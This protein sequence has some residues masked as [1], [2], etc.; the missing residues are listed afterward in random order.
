MV[1]RKEQ[2]WNQRAWKAEFYTPESGRQ[3]PTA[4]SSL[5]QRPHEES[6]VRVPH[7]RCDLPDL[8]R[9]EDECGKTTIG[10]LSYTMAM[11]AECRSFLPT[12]IE[13]LLR[14][15]S[16]HIEWYKS[17]GCKQDKLLLQVVH[18]VSYRRGRTCEIMLKQQG[19]YLKQT[20]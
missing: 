6:G 17:C 19:Q 1:W 10:W 16:P 2:Y 11:I 15:V 14:E 8:Q 5:C 3:L 13:L 4:S 12:L 20:V 9:A 7:P 18:A